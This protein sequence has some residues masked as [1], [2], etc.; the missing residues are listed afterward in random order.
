[1]INHLKHDEIN[2]TL[3]DKCIN[4]NA[5][6]VPYALSWYLDVVAP[7]WEA[8]VL[9][10]YEAVMPLPYRKKYGINYIF[11][12]PFVQQ[13]GV[14]GPEKT[15]VEPFI[16]AIPKAFSYIDLNFNEYNTI[17][18]KH[19]PIN[20]T[21]TLLSL[22]S[23]FDK[24]QNSFA[25]NTRRNIKKAFKAGY[26]FVELYDIKPII[27]LFKANKGKQLDSKTD[28]KLLQ[29]LVI[30]AQK[31]SACQ[32]YGVKTAEGQICAGAVFINYNNRHVFLFSGNN[33][34]A[35]QHGAMHFLI[36]NYIEKNTKTP[37][38]LDFEGSNNVALERF[39]L[40][41]GSSAT[42]YPKIKINRLPM[43]LRLFKK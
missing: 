31:H 36:S 43:P 19:S 14:F 28:Y 26:S 12:P 3:W 32:L 40:S 9:G 27:A 7:G 11:T 30:T 25:E 38:V 42:Q 5:R 22:N 10:Q 13:L 6:G 35:R 2:K 33:E 24:L 39:Y 17:A 23:P 41:F 29:D 15:A 1:M 20:N 37:A 4:L 18:A 16:E 21:N 34:E 8:L